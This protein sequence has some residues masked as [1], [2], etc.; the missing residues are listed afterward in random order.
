MVEQIIENKW[1]IKEIAA[2]LSAY[3]SSEVPERN[4]IMFFSNYIIKSGGEDDKIR[5]IPHRIKCVAESL[6]VL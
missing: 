4:K 6:G 5:E 2:E 1:G 3:A